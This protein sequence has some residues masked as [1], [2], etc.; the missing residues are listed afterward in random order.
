MKSQGY[1]VNLKMIQ[2]IKHKECWSHISDKYWSSD[3][4]HELE[5]KKI[6]IICQT[7]VD[8]NGDVSAT[9]NCLVDMIP[10]ISKR[11]IQIIK[12]KEDWTEISDTYFK[13]GDF[14]TILTSDEIKLCKDTLITFNMDIN[15][16]YSYLYP[17]IPNLTK[18]K[19]YKI[20]SKIK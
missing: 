6:H 4:L 13:K 14:R 7:L 16:V 18:R 1:D 19:L 15:K 2:H 11:F 17:R 20:K 10:D 8:T 3:Y 9:Y 5:L 12:Y